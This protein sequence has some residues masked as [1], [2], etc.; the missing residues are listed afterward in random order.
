MSFSPTGRTGILVRMRKLLA[1]LVAVLGSILL[2]AN[3]SVWDGTPIPGSAGSALSAAATARE[4]A[5]F[6]AALLA[7][8]AATAIDVPVVGVDASEIADSFGAPR[9]ARLHQGVDIFAPRGTYVTSATPGIIARIGTNA[10]GGTVVYVLGPGGERYYYAHLDS[11]D[12]LLARGQIVGT[13]TVIG[14][15]GTSGNATGTPPHL[16]FGI[17]GH[18]DAQDPLPRLNRLR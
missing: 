6:S 11:V 12:T 4:H 10:L 7:R 15:V 14:R 9:G 8:P 2:L 13:T 16:H 3:P 5:V 17:Y 18:G 1:A